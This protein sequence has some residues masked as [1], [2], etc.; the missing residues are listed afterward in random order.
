VPV[1]CVCP[2]LSPSFVRVLTT[3]DDVAAALGRRCASRHGL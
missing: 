3:V 2:L 1:F